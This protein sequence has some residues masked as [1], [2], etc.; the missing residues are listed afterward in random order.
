MKIL[1]LTDNFPPERNAP[2][3]RTFEHCRRWAENG[4]DVTV[5]T[6]APN[7]PEGRVHEGYR[8]RW[9]HTETMS[10][11][12]VVRVK[13]YITANEG[14]FRRTIDYLSFML[15]GMIGAAFQKRPDIVIG[16]SPQ[17]FT[18][19][20]AYLTALM[21]RRPFVL[22]VR[23][24]WPSSIVEVGA[25][26]EGPLIRLLRAMERFIY[27]RAS[28]I[29]S[30]T[31]S[32]VGH[33]CAA[34]VAE[35]RVKVIRN[36]VNLADFEGIEPCPLNPGDTNGKFR[37]GYIGT[38]G[39]A[40]GLD[41]ILEAA[42]AVARADSTIEFAFT[43]SGAERKNLLAQTRRLGLS[44][45]EFRMPV[46]RERIAQEWSRMDLGLVPLKDKPVFST[47]IP[48]K[49]FEAMASGTPI[50]IAAPLGEA[51]DLVESS[52]CGVHVPPGNPRLL[53]QAILSLRNDPDK[54]AEMQR[55]SRESARKFDRRYLAD[56]MQNALEELLHVPSA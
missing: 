8:N 9:Y 14:F 19:W 10:G 2:A 6:G 56:A 54:L 45:V 20:A 33:I 37:V 39:M 32:F 53:A 15:S 28:L 35:S 7:F 30:V 40:H 18:A 36:G 38:M 49:I 11:I 48:S 13:T 12:R 27:R 46:D 4:T 51:T 44:N 50:L 25:M 21:K 43:G 1:F 5:I 24:L 22:E 47:V 23:D 16:T 41:T 31:N 17:F 26:R 3:I 52:G 42:A 55:M 34:G 29:V